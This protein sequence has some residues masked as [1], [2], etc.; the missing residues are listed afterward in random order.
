[1]FYFPVQPSIFFYLYNL[2]GFI[3][4][5]FLYLC[6]LFASFFLSVPFLCFMFLFLISRNHSLE[7]LMQNCPLR[8]RKSSADGIPGCTFML[9]EQADVVCNIAAEYQPLRRKLLF[10]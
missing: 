1:V 6:Y 3:L 5:L 2:P 4:F 9:H 10:S 7:I 8:H